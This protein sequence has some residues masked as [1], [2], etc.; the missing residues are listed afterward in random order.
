MTNNVEARA[1]ELPG[2]YA[3]V[4]DLSFVALVRPVLG[5]CTVKNIFLVK[6]YTVMYAQTA[7]LV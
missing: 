6:A 7:E 3:S 1:S 4:R 2:S 5:I